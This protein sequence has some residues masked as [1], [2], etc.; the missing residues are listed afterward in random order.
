MLESLELT[1]IVN[2]ARGH[3]PRVPFQIRDLHLGR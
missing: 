3:Q 1:V 2:D